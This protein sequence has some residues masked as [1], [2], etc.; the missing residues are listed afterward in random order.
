MTKDGEMSI[1]MEAD[2]HLAARG[3][4]NQITVESGRRSKSDPVNKKL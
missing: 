1:E 2:E 3:M 4:K